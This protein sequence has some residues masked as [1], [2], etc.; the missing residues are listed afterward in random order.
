M[1]LITLKNFKTKRLITF[2]AK[3]YT[4][5][6]DDVEYI[7]C[8]TEYELLSNFLAWWESVEPEVITGWN[9]ELFDMTYL[10]NR[11]QRI[12][13]EK[14][15][16]RLSP[17]GLVDSDFIE[18]FGRRQQRYTLAGVSVLD[19]LDMYKKF[20]Y[21]N[22]ENYRLNT[23]AQIELG[24]EKL[25]H[26]EYETFKDFYTKGWT[27]FVDYN[28]IDVDLVDRLEEKMKLIDLVLLMAYDAHCNY[29]DTFAQVRLWDI[30][31][32]NYLRRKNI[33][34]P[35]MSKS[36]KKDQYTGAY[37]KEPKV[38]AY[39]WVVSFDL[40]SLYPSLIRF[41]NISPETLLPDRNP[42]ADVE[43]MILKGAELYDGTDA[44]VAANG[45][46]Y[47]KD[48]TGFMPELVTKMYE[49]RVNYKQEMLKQK[50]RLE[51]L[52]GR[53]RR[54]PTP[55]LREQHAECVRAVTKWSN[56]QMVRKICLNSLYGAIGNQYFRHYKLDNAE[57]ITLTGQ[58]A[59]RWIERKMNEF[60][61]TA[62]KTDGEDYVIASDTD[63]IYLNLG[64]LVTTVFGERSRDASRVVPVLDQF[65]E[66]KI[67]PYIDA[68]YAELSEYL[69]CY[70]E[71]LIMKRE[72]V[73]ERG[74]WT[75]K[76][77]YILNVWDNEGVR[78]E[79]PKLKMMGIEAVK[80]S[81][82]APCRKYIAD[83][84]K[85]LM[86][87]TED[88]LID[89]IEVC[90]QEFN[91]L[92]IDEIAFPRSA[93]NLGKF[94]DS[95]TIYRKSTPMH[96]RGSLL[97]N[98]LLKE[99]EVLHK[100]NLIQDGEKIKFVYLK[101]PNPI[102]EN[103]MSFITEFPLELGLIDFIDYDTMFTKA[104]L[105]PLQ[106]ILDVLGWKTE[107]VTTLDDFFS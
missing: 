8:P 53:L 17:W 101:T 10:C 48:R 3:P 5:T 106:V 80:S 64:P 102:S 14:S 35:L 77:R 19:Y 34:L 43:K 46:R 49:E 103:V 15:L 9:V 75:A 41:L 12:L 94:A 47:S 58:V 26:S 76:K 73:S 21:T 100:Y 51:E 63:S 18:T 27:K 79:E 74:I 52:E 36:D 30:I 59:I 90:R 23:I 67:V 93:N 60:L 54:N 2:G 70:E 72:C 39:D 38:G 32:Y 104:F 25:D 98:F 7:Y 57:A 56:F 99:K 65:C 61:N 20:T 95:G 82:P 6:R 28:L 68:S 107:K 66:D 24:Q 50:R 11:I 91:S 87:G 89:Y 96:V 83:S 13:G 86:R 31:I 37:V 42:Q 45:A 16:K 92:P 40:N 4:P 62:L 29:T 55:E 33:A 69:N 81:T 1:L 85:I 88:E 78:Y 22:R 44:C 71:T 97:F 84:L 105:D